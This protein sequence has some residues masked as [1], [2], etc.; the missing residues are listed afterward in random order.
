MKIGIV[1]EDACLRC[2]HSTALYPEVTWQWDSHHLWF[3]QPPWFA[4]RDTPGMAL[5]KLRWCCFAGPLRFLTPESSLEAGRFQW[6][7]TREWFSIFFS[8]DSFRLWFVRQCKIVVEHVVSQSW[9]LSGCSLLDGMDNRRG[10]GRADQQIRELWMRN[11]MQLVW[12]Y[13]C[14]VGRGWFVFCWLFG[15]SIAFAKLAALWNDVWW[16]HLAGWRH[17]QQIV[18]RFWVIHHKT[19]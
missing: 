17:S 16:L 11:W 7:E 19:W 12:F 10:G 18:K 3:S 15:S 2:G 5:A 4:H 1:L 8:G 14:F 6:N 13:F 9:P